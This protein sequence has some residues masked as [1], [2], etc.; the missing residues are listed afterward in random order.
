MS[1]TVSHSTSAP[2]RPPHSPLGALL[3]G[4]AAGALASA[5]Q[6]IFF[7]TTTKLATAAP[8]GVLE[9]PDPEQATESPTET[10]ARRAAEMTRHELPIDKGRAGRMVHYAFGSA[11][12]GAYGLSA[13]T[14]PAL[15]GPA[16]GGVF[17]VLVW[18]VSV[19]MILPAFR[20]T[21]WP[22][23]YPPRYHAYEIAAHIAY[24]AALGLAFDALTPRRWRLR[25]VTL[26]RA[27]DAPA[28]IESPPMRI[29]APDMLEA[30]AGI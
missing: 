4:L 22:Q 10:V 27:S 12:G 26:V 20:L 6:E 18:A 8:E 5:A 23:R 9:P 28:A 2:A 25:D 30:G 3:R 29:H 7:R 16:G 15:T 11:W 14:Y 1:T 19:G 17:G 21:A 24:G 13:A